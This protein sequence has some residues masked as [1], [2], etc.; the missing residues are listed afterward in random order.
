MKLLVTLRF[1][2]GLTVRR[3]QSKAAFGRKQTF[4]ATRTRSP[5]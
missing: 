4:A 1:A 3:F 2:D 5:T